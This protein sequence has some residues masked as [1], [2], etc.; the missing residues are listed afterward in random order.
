MWLSSWLSVYQTGA[1]WNHYIKS[2]KLFFPIKISGV[3]HFETP[4]RLVF[5]FHPFSPTF[6]KRLQVLLQSV[7]H[8]EQTK[9]GCLYRLRTG[10][11]YWTVNATKNWKLRCPQE[12]S[13]ATIDIP[14]TT[15]EYQWGCV[16]T[17]QR[18][19]EWGDRRT[20]S[21]GRKD[22]ETTRTCAK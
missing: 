3:T 6:K 20:V 19:S 14:H 21:L 12:D 4:E 16:Q 13:W 9:P 1:S 17:R 8:L 18:N 2:S 22:G 5:F 10:L 7:G 11:Q 15:P